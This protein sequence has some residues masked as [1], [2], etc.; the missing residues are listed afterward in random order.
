MGV[1]LICFNCRPVSL[2]VL[3]LNILVPHNK[4]LLIVSDKNAHQN[5][6]RNPHSMC[7]CIGCVIVAPIA[8][9]EVPLLSEPVRKCPFCQ[10]ADLVIKKKRSGG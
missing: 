10:Q 1:C 5:Y 7:L 6:I 8:A 2:T 4:L 3:W 9:D